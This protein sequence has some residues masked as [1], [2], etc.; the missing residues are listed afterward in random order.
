MYY[1]KY[2]VCHLYEVWKC[3]ETTSQTTKINGTM[4][5]PV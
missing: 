1:V 3:F 2:C 4:L 5:N